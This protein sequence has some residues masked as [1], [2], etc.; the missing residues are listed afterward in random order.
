MMSFCAPNQPLYVILLL[1]TGYRARNYTLFH[2]L[3][4]LF[5]DNNH[6]LEDCRCLLVASRPSSFADAAL[7]TS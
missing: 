1:T 2:Q 7:A 4:F 6:A 3:Y 5:A